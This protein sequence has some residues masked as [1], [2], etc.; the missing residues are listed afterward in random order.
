[1]SSVPKTMIFCEGSKSMMMLNVSQR[2][3]K[4]NQE[5]IKENTLYLDDKLEQLKQGGYNIALTK[6]CKCKKNMRIGPWPER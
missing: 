6:A 4:A 1:M 3:A 5:K 2:F